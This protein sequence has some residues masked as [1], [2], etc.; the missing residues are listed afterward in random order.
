VRMK[1][2]VKILGTVVALALL[3]SIAYVSTNP[4]GVSDWWKLRGYTPEPAIVSIADRL[5][6]TDSAR[7][8]FYVYDPKIEDSEVFNTHCTIREV[9][10]V[11]G[12]YNGSNI[13]V[14]NVVDPQLN[15]V[16]E[17]TA[18][19]ELLHAAYDRLSLSELD[20]IDEL[21]RKQFAKISD[22][23]LVATIKAYRDRDPSVVPNELHSILATEVRDLDP[24]LEQYYSRYF[25]D[26]LRVV[27]FSEKYEQVFSD[28]KAKVER[29]DAELTLLKAQIDGLES[30]LGLRAIRIT[31]EK[32]VLDRLY[33]QNNAEEYNSRVPAYNDSVERYNGDL[34]RYRALVGE[35]NAKVAVRNESTVEQNNLI[36]SLSSNA[37][38]L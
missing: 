2:L 17:V 4:R 25:T 22:E 27:A 7:R 21:T 8:L 16:Q 29:L 6:M 36:E 13:Y 23:R 35:Y 28:I 3:G 32:E 1:R 37:E 15:G 20:K 11:L 38:E 14:F 18:A 5:T 33:E 12:C 10:I 31:N 24:E 19:H 9:S 34:E 26:R 30:D